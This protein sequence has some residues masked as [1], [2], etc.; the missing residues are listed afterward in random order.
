VKRAQKRGQTGNTFFV[1]EKCHPQTI[2]VVRTRAEP[3]GYTVVVGDHAS[4]NFGRPDSSAR[5]VQY[6][7]TDGTI[8]D[9]SDFCDRAHAAG[10]LVTVVPT[11]LLAL[12]LL[13]PP[14]EFGA[15]IAVGN[16]QR[17]RRAAGLWRATRRV[18]GDKGRSQAH[19]AGPLVGVSID[20]EG[21]PAM[22]LSL[23]TREQHIRRDKAT[24][25][26]CTA[27][28]LLAVMASMYAVYHGPEGLRA[29]PG[30]CTC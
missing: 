5:C 29:S 1:S 10:A 25:N 7:D 11:D 22:R 15:D 6:P 19:H 21:N 16:S 18:H 12:T 30:V 4:Y 24:S 13:T 17:F 23:Q 28:V 26:I 9:L 8:L 27:Q 20:A 2:D 14:G 3:L